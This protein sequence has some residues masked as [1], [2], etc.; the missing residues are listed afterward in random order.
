VLAASLTSSRQGHTGY[1]FDCVLQADGCVLA[2]HLQEQS[3]TS[4]RATLTRHKR[5][6]RCPVEAITDAREHS[7]HLYLLC[8]LAHTSCN[9]QTCQIR[10]LQPITSWSEHF[11]AGLQI[12]MTKIIVTAT[13]DDAGSGE[14][15]CAFFLSACQPRVAMC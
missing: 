15:W 2:V 4:D 12:D 8:T 11:V 5:T 9:F 7:L 13:S 3:V 14:E 6:L 10:H 1:A